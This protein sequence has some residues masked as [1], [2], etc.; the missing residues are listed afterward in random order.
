MGQSQMSLY[1]DNGYRLQSQV[2]ILYYLLLVV[3]VAVVVAVVI[4]VVVPI[5]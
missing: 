1:N 2:L 3:A 4:A 5:V